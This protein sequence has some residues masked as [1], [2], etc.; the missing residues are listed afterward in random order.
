MRTRPRQDPQRLLG[1]HHQ[2]DSPGAA[3][4][5]PPPLPS[6]RVNTERP[7][8]AVPGRQRRV[9]FAPRKAPPRPSLTAALLRSADAAAPL[10]GHAWA[11]V[12]RQQEQRL[13][14]LVLDGL[15]DLYDQRYGAPPHRSERD[16]HAEVWLTRLL[17]AVSVALEGSTWE[18]QM[19]S[20]AS[21][22]QELLRSGVSGADLS[23][24]ALDATDH[25]RHAIAA[26]F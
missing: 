16:H 12:D 7:G 3:R 11:V 1:G 6:C 23:D 26:Y 24:A 17:I 9:D 2:P 25:L 8:C 15:D 20:A 19:M 22:I 21:A 10:T 14:S 13:L 18:S 5:G 4:P